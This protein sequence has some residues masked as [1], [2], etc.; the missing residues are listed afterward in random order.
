[1]TSE[2]R[3]AP[4]PTRRRLFNLGGF[5]YAPKR[6][7][8]SVIVVALAA[9]VV[10]ASASCDEE[11]KEC[12]PGD[13]LGCSCAN[14]AVGYA[15]CSPS[16]SFTSTACVCDGTTPGIDG[17]APDA[18]SDDAEAE[19]DAATCA[20]D[21]GPDAGLKK[22]AESCARNEE[23]ES[24]RCESFAGQNICTTTCTTV[25]QCPAPADACTNRGVCRPPL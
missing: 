22:Y 25:D 14:G 10:L 6:M 20:L 1:M 7:R 18:R 24:C 4:R 21:A 9:I 15:A 17:G 2:R 19:P 5:F 8:G 13:F 3:R 16:G 23:C 12:Y 11:Y